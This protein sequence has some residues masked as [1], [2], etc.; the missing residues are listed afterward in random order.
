MP[1]TVRRAFFPLQAT[2]QDARRHNVIPSNLCEAAAVPEALPTGREKVEGH[3]LSRAQVD[4]LAAKVAEADPVYGLLV[5]FA[6]GVGLRTS[7]LAGLRLRNLRLRAEKW[8]WS[9]P[10]RTCPA[11]AG[12]SRTQE[13]QEPAT[14]SDPSRQAAAQPWPLPGGPPAPR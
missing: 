4:A 6:A 11:P 1:A 12:S 5:R 9:A 14:G 3:F 2:F 10:R 8:R 7:E 13:R